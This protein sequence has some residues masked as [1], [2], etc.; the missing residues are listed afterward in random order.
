VVYN[1]ND[2]FAIKGRIGELIYA[3]FVETKYNWSCYEEA[4]LQK[5][6]VDFIVTEKKMTKKVDVKLSDKLGDFFSMAYSKPTGLRYPFR[7]GG[8]ANYLE[9]VSLDWNGYMKDHLER[10]KSK[11]PN[12]EQ[13][14]KELAK[15]I[16]EEELNKLVLVLEKQEK[17]NTHTDLCELVVAHRTCE[18]LETELKK[19][20]TYKDFDEIL[21]KY[22]HSIDEVQTQD[23][24]RFKP[25]L[26]SLKS[27][28]SIT[29]NTGQKVLTKRD[30]YT[31]YGMMIAAEFY[32]N[33]MPSRNNLYN[34]IADS[35]QVVNTS[36]N[37]VWPY[38]KTK[39]I[40]IDEA[41]KTLSEMKLESLKWIL[42]Q[43][44][45]TK[46]SFKKLFNLTQEQFEQLLV[47]LIDQKRQDKSAK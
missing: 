46:S 9:I 39:S 28:Y 45:S 11:Y 23:V 37:V 30:C 2:L 8:L 15:Y 5:V 34:N 29:D 21:S 24:I 16:N 35:S 20:T 36:S 22:V 13:A 17:R 26:G 18:R 31:R 14:K 27:G 25:F 40:I 33:A 19:K 38:R 47:V 6:G 44:Q 43:N 12:E 42:E 3:I 4:D 41:G 1:E 32:W 10:A 7:D